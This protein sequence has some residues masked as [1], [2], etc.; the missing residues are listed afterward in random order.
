MPSEL[1]KVADAVA[2]AL[3]A[4]S[5]P[6]PFTAVRHYQPVFDLA[7]MADLHVT[8]VPRGIEVAQVARAKGSFDCK[9]DV[10]VQRRFSRGDAAELDPLMELVGEIA[11]SFRGKRLPGMPDAAW[12]KTEHVP[13]Y[14]PEHMQE[15]RQFTSVMTLTFRV[16]R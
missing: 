8:V 15:L 14:A 10:A 4:A 2:A 3:N 5:F 16:V 11:E 6:M 13:V 1:I 12:V 7:E 9:V